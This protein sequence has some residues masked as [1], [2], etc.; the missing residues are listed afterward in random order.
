MRSNIIQSVNNPQSQLLTLLS[1]LDSN[2]LD[3]P[4]LAQ[5]MDEL[6]LNDQAPRP[7]DTTGS[8]TDDKEEVFAASSGHPV[9]PVVPI[10]FRDI[11]HYGQHAQNIQVT[12][13]VVGTAQWT[14]RVVWRE[15]SKDFGGDQG[16][17]EER[18]LVG[19]RN[20]VIRGLFRRAIAS[21]MAI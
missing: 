11:A 4:N 14:D 6:V 21:G 19:G 5:R 18:R 3:M 13:G 15:S 17:R 1:L 16:V 20:G 8:V 7:D 9:V 2:I 12:P 10:I